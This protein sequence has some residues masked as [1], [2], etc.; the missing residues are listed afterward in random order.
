MLYIETFFNHL[1]SSYLISV[2]QTDRETC[3]EYPIKYSGVVNLKFVKNI[4]YK[5]SFVSVTCWKTKGA[6]NLSEEVGEISRE[7]IE[8]ATSAEV[9]ENRS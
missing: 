6:Y 4:K 7:Q 3:S 9:K 2:T 5:V 8:D 1:I